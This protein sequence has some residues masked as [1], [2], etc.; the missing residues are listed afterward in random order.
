MPI[1]RIKTYFQD[2]EFGFITPAQGGRDVYFRKR[3]V[4][5]MG[6]EIEPGA[7]VEYESRPGKEPGK[8][9]A[10]TVVLK[11]F[12]E[13]KPEA[14][15]TAHASEGPPT[16]SSLPPECI[17][18]SFYDQG[19]QPEP[20]LFYGAPEKSASI[21]RRAGLKAS[22]FRQLY[23]GFLAFA[24]PLRDGRID[25]GDARTRFGAFYVERVVRQ[26]QRG[27]LPPV[28]KTLIDNHRELALRDKREMLGLFRYLTNIYCYFGDSGKD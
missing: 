19:N 22:Q 17:F 24:G 14:E 4:K 27:V 1:G 8:L 18:Q 16:S 5:D 28:V 15:P 2:R 10:V 21:F 20:R 25:F 9:E 26:A 3:V 13:E 23:Q 12:A 11:G 7:P 6:Y